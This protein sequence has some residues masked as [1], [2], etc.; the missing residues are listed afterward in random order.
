MAVIPMSKS[1][2]KIMSTFSDE[3]MAKLTDVCLTYGWITPANENGI[4]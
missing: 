3:Q 1:P 2:T 4:Q